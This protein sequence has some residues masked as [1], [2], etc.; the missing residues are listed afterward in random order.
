MKNLLKVTLIIGVAATA[1]TV[2]ASAGNHLAGLRGPSTLQP[3]L[4]EFEGRFDESNSFTTLRQERRSQTAS[5]VQH[6]NNYGSSYAPTTYNHASQGQNEYVTV[7]EFEGRFTQPQPHSS[8]QERR[9]QAPTYTQPAYRGYS[10]SYVSPQSNIENY[11]YQKPKK[12][13]YGNVYD[14]ESGRCGTDCAPAPI[15][16][17]YR[18]IQRTYTAPQTQYYRCWDGEIVANSNGCKAKTVTQ[19]IPQ[20][21]CWDGEVVTDR[22]GCKLKTVTREVY[23]EPTTSYSNSYSS[24]SSTTANCPSGTSKQSDGTC[25][26]SSSTSFTSYGSGSSY[27][28][29]P[30]YGSIP[31][32]CPAGTIAQ[33]DGTCLESAAPSYSSPYS[34]ASV[35]FFSTPEPST[36]SYGYNNDNSFGLRSYLPKRK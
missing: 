15:Q 34:G 11:R 28:S 3:S 35:E 8:W 19:T 29:S 5:P 33:S 20:Y 4:A 14:Y 21:R 7:N 23:A 16:R 36:P 10:Q 6:S 31:T 9:L 22:K 27:N 18:P 2:P 24:G 30:S 32:N 26:E 13:K 12:S 17:Y 1:I 25:L